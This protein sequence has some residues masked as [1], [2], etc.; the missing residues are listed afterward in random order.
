MPVTIRTGR[1]EMASGGTLFLDE[2]GNI[3]LQQQAKLLIGYTE[4]P[5]F[6]AGIQSARFRWISG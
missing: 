6:P 1:F 3:T 2:I 5:G 4:P